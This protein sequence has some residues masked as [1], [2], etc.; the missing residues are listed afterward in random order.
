MVASCSSLPLRAEMSIRK[1]TWESSLSEIL[2]WLT[3]E[4]PHT[5]EL[6]NKRLLFTDEGEKGI[7]TTVQIQFL[8]KQ[9]SKFDHY[10][11]FSQ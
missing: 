10:K 3:V 5:R 2:S 8:N 11:D 7:L 4:G 1:E 6:L 9:N